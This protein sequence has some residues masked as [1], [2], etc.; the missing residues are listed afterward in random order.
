[1]PTQGYVSDGNSTTT[2]LGL[3]TVFNGTYEETLHW[4]SLQVFILSNVA[5]TADGL[6]F[7]WSEDGVTDHITDNVFTYRITDDDGNP[8]SSGQSFTAD[9][10][11]NFFRLQ[12]NKSA[13]D[14]QTTFVVCTTLREH[15]LSVPHRRLTRLL[16]DNDQ[17]I[18]T[19]GQISRFQEIQID[20]GNLLGAGGVFNSAVQSG[21]R[22][23]QLLISAF[24]DVV[25][26]VGGLQIKFYRDNTNIDHTLSYTYTPGVTRP[27]K[28]PMLS[29]NFS[30]HYTNGPTPQAAFRLSYFRNVFGDTA[31][32][33]LGHP[34]APEWTSGDGEVIPILKRLATLAVLPATGRSITDRSLAVAAGGIAEQLMAA[35]SNRTALAVA[36]PMHQS[37]ILWVSPVGTA[38]VNGQGSF[39]IFPGGMWEPFVPPTGAISVLAPTTGTRVSAW[40]AS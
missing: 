26:A 7:I 11:A 14:N 23:N 24:S 35:N 33:S 1:M 6:K 9:I 18:I 27:I 16:Q 15:V 12:F 13:L 37:E 19:H 2:P 17:G 5:S 25:S 22:Y 32:Y 20:E 31:L 28:V 36:N 38:A 21:R 39:P 30:V 8:T 29:R 34:N 10:R 4:G 3:G 40:E